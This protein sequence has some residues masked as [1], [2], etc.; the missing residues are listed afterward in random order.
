[1]LA[2]RSSPTARAGSPRRWAT[3]AVIAAILLA[4]APRA[5]D[6]TPACATGAA[7]PRAVCDRPA[8]GALPR[9]PPPVAPHAPPTGSVGASH[10]GTPRHVIGL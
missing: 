5:P 2:L 8:A 1:M 9:D 7:P 4:D 6:R 10:R 3:G